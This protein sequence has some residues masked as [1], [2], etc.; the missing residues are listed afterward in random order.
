MDSDVTI[1]ATLQMSAL[2]FS[3]GLSEVQ[4]ARLSTNVAP[5][6]SSK[7]LHVSCD[8]VLIGAASSAICFQPYG[9]EDRTNSVNLP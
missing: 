5:T 7:V 4:V 8:A 1:A 6:D 3:K 9:V 2:L